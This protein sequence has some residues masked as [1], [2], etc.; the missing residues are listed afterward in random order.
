MRKQIP[1]VAIMPSSVRVDD[2]AGC[3]FC[4][5]SHPVYLGDPSLDEPMNMWHRYAENCTNRDMHR[6][7]YSLGCRLARLGGVTTRIP[8]CQLEWRTCRWPLLLERCQRT[9]LVGVIGPLQSVQKVPL[10]WRWPRVVVACKSG[11]K[12]FHRSVG[13]SSRCL[14][15]IRSYS[16]HPCPL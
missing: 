1:P 5:A 2:P 15:N 12:V 9:E 11:S 8:L 7:H 3:S 10:P 4:K 16:C 6:H 13:S 14:R